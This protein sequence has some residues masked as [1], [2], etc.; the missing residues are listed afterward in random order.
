MSAL[1]NE[2]KKAFCIVSI[3]VSA[4]IMLGSGAWF[5]D[6]VTTPTEE[7]YEMGGLNL[8]VPAGIFFLGSTCA[9]AGGIMRLQQF[10]REEGKKTKE[11]DSQG[12]DNNVNE[13]KP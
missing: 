13:P 1:K 3:A 2:L 10:G 8:T 6:E 4:P 5:Y 9:F 7:K 11:N 12:V